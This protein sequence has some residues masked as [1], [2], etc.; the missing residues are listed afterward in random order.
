MT[1]DSSTHTPADKARDIQFQWSD[2]ELCHLHKY[3]ITPIKGTGPSAPKV[4][5]VMDRLDLEDLSGG[6]FCDGPQKYV[7]EDLIQELG[8]PPGLFWL[9]TVTACPTCHQEQDPDEIPRELAPSAKEAS[10]KAC[11]PRLHQEIHA[12][13]PELVIACGSAAVKALFVGRA[14]P[15]STSMGSILEARIPGGV[16]E[17]PIPVLI[18]HSMLTVARTPQYPDPNRVWEKT[19]KSLEQGIDA[20]GQLLYMRSDDYERDQNES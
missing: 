4:V 9:T 19:R 10:I 6:S 20:L 5:V 15:H 18:L 13:E 17:Y 11:R 14:P 7:F 3:R 12:L 2:C 16:F 1:T 8:L